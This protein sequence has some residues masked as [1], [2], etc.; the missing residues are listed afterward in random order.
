MLAAF[1]SFQAPSDLAL[2]AV[3]QPR[4]IAAVHD[5][6]QGG[7]RHKERGQPR[8][9]LPVENCRRGCARDQ[10]GK[11]RVARDE[12]N[13]EPDHTKRNERNPDA[14]AEQQADESRNSFAASEAEPERKQMAQKG[15][16][17]GG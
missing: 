17:G 5:P 11:R 1:R 15:A 16:A 10:G 3:E 7:E 8:I 14:E 9:T 2:R 4:D 12:G 13:A 6:E